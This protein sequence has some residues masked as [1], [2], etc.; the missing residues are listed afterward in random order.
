MKLDK[1]TSS[2]V[3]VGP[4]RGF[5]AETE[6]ELYVITA[7]HCLPR[8]PDSHPASYTGEKTYIDLLAPLGQTPNIAAE[9]LFADPIADLAVLKSPDNQALPEQA[10][11]YRRLLADSGSI[12]VAPKDGSQLWALSLSNEWISYSEEVMVGGMSGSP[13]VSDSGHAV[14]IL[15]TGAEFMNPVLIDDLPAWLVRDLKGKRHFS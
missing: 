1:L 10:D 11:S 15:S 8:L 4:G 14:A 5:V 2:I 9:L 12:P 6:D 13:V 3:Q 7:A